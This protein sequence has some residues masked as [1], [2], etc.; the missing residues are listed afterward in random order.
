MIGALRVK[1]NIKTRI[2]V[3]E[4]FPCHSNSFVYFHGKF[5]IILFLHQMQ[6]VN[7]DFFTLF[8]SD[9]NKDG[10]PT[11]AEFIEQSR[12]QEYEKSSMHNTDFY[13]SVKIISFK[14]NYDQI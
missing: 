13:P 6:Y 2:W 5:C 14:N 8:P 9:F 7:L 10:V 12:W 1:V 4:T 3:S 11:K